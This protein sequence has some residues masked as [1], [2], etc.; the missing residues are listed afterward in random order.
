MKTFIKVALIGLMGCFVG[1]SPALVS[2]HGSKKVAKHQN[3]VADKE[4]LSRI[5][6]DA[7]L[8]Q[9][10]KSGLLVPLQENLFIKID[11]RLDTKYCYVRP[12]TRD[13]L[14]NMGMSFGTRFH[15]KS[16]Q[17]NSAVRTVAKQKQLR[18]INGNAAPTEGPTQ[19]SHTT[20]ATVDI[21]KK[22]LSEDQLDWLRD[23]FRNKKEAGKIDVVEEKRQL[24][25]HVMVF[26][27]PDINKG[28][29]KKVLAHNKKTRK[30][31]K[32]PNH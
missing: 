1:S 24:V 21:A 2:L 22:D 23:Y 7:Q 15:G 29:K 8:K 3:A 9:F 17:I 5:A 25:F 11:S 10:I 4:N 12:W 20:G 6:N 19:S 27:S 13:F 26:K 14:N 16:L 32:H 31:V 18:Q 28:T 30:E